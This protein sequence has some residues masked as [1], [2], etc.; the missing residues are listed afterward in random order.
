VEIE[1]MD[2]KKRVKNEKMRIENG[3]YRKGNKKW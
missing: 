3:N 1:G 2:I